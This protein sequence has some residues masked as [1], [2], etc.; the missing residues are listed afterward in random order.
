MTAKPSE[1]SEGFEENQRQNSE[2]I[3]RNGNKVRYNA[4]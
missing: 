4:L 2:G 3:I 1:G